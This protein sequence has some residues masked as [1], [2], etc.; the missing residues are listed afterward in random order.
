MRHRMIG[1]LFC[2]ALLG[3]PGA[4]HA[5]EQCSADC[6]HP[7]KA[8]VCAID[9]TTP[10]TVTSI[11]AVERRRLVLRQALDIGDEL[12]GLSEDSL[13]GLTCP[14]G[15]DVKLQGRFRTVIMPPVSGQDCALNLLAGSANVLTNQPTQLT[16]GE[17][18]MGSKQTVYSMR[19]MREQE[20]PR[21][22]CVVF[23]GE[24]EVQYRK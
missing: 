13:V 11:G 9:G 23:E 17:T 14:G 20:Q 15:S 10:I 8:C 24:A 5:A 1:S 18:V 3:L 16:S 22:E 19:V 4:S 7:T 21:F 6:T 12:T 2:L